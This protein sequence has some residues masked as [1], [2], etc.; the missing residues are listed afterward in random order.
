MGQLPYQNTQVISDYQASPG[1][2]SDATGALAAYQ[3][4]QSQQNQGTGDPSTITVGSSVTPDP[5]L[6]QASI[7]NSTL[8]SIQD[9]VGAGELIEPPQYP[10]PFEGDENAAGGYIQGRAGGGYI[11]G[12]NLGILAPYHQRLIDGLYAGGRIH[13]Q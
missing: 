13:Y 9:E 8:P 5:N 6:V 12:S 4:F 7:D 10:D 3:N 11:G 2:M 1:F